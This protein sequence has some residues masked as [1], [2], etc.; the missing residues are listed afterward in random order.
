MN[1]TYTV[2]N[3]C[4]NKIDYAPSTGFGEKSYGEPAVKSP[5]HLYFTT[6]VKRYLLVVMS[7][8]TAIT[9]PWVGERQRRD[10]AVT[11]TVYQEVLGRFISR[12]EALQIARE[13]LEE[14]EQE[15]LAFAEYEA[16]RGIQY[17]L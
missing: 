8:F 1:S 16:A 7:S 15:R 11:Q 6:K 4:E 10:A 3:V 9:D 17:D 13:I 2:D 5:E 14:A 12:T